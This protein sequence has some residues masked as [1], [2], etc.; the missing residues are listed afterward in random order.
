[1]GACLR[2]PLPPPSQHVQWGQEVS[3][4]A[5]QLPGGMPP[6]QPGQP[7][8]EGTEAPLSQLSGPAGTI[9]TLRT[10]NIGQRACT[11][12]C[13]ATTAPF[14]ATLPPALSPLASQLRGWQMPVASLLCH[15]LLCAG[16]M[17]SLKREKYKILGILPTDRHR[18]K[19]WR[20]PWGRGCTLGAG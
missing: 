19:G 15:W 6:S 20:S 10:R 18:C 5:S 7:T 9:A 17:L 11:G 16:P 1:M 13:Q 2:V 12:S 14:C 8:W 4:L 3:D